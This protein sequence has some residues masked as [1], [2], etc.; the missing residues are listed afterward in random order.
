MAYVVEVKILL[1]VQDTQRIEMTFLTHPH[2]HNN[3]DKKKLTKK[4]F[5]LKKGTKIINTAV[6]IYCKYGAT[7]AIL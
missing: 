2:G 3:G 5:K 7:D 4:T 1:H 6:Q